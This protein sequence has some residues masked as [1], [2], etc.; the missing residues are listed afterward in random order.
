MTPIP[1]GPMTPA[2][3]AIRRSA[4]EDTAKVAQEEADRLAK[5]MNPDLSHLHRGSPEA[6]ESFKRVERYA[7]ALG[8]RWLTAEHIART[9]RALYNTEAPK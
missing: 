4:L 2:E 9:I 5:V 7:D 1:K 6:E 3:R 8:P